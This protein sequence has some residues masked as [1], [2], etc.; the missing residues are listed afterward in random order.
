VQVLIFI[1]MF[2]VFASG[3]CGHVGVV[4][5]CASPNFHCHVF[6]VCKW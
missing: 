1:V 5:G 2:L 6:S 4:G 3:D